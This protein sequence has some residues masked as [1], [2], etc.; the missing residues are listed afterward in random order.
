MTA[1]AIL[2]LFFRL[3]PSAFMEIPLDTAF[4]IPD[5][6]CELV[7]HR[8]ERC[9]FVGGCVRDFL[10]GRQPKDYDVEVYG[11]DYETLAAI[12]RRFG[13]VD[14]VGKSFGVIKLTTRRGQEAYDISIARRETRIAGQSGHK[15]F[16]VSHDLDLTPREGAE[17]RDFTINALMVDPKTNALLDF[18]GGR[19]DLRAGVLRHTSPKFTEDPLRPL[20]LMQ[21]A[22][23][24]DMTVA[25]ETLSLCREMLHE[26]RTLPVERIKEEWT[27]WAARSKNPARGL[28]ALA[29][30]GWIE[31]YPELAAMLRTPQDPIWH[32]EGAT[33]DGQS[34]RPDSLWIHIK[35]CCNAL[36]DLPQWQSLDAENRAVYML[37]VLCHDLGK[38]ATTHEEFKR[39][40]MCIV[41]PGHDIAGGEPTERFLRG[42]GIQQSLIERVRPL[43][44][45]H[46]AH[47]QQGGG[48]T[49][50]RR[51]ARRVAPDNIQG[52]S[53]VMIADHSGRPPL[54]RE[55]PEGT[56][57]LLEMAHELAV[58]D[59]APK[60]I[61]MGRHLLELGLRPGPEI[62]LIV[63]EAYERQLDGEFDT[64]EGALAWYKGRV[65]PG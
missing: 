3:P 7:L 13:Q 57:R 35:H 37:A 20:R 27:K 56:T 52:L 29:A 61:L 5:D 25:P 17:R 33:P 60:P 51:L 40:R 30:T 62:G 38:P 1:A 11:L 14:L 23:R 41:S 9:Y 18:F 15:A 21:F 65:I 19:E 46:M 49:M 50:V 34:S 26:Y 47:L 53:L 44:E 6:L 24:F 32:P 31:L 22:G 59:A 42:I 63:K 48:P 10:L 43:V 12:L 64:V 8:L 28:D 54:P 16:D 4:P 36:A 45:N 39:G 55:V 2:R 58:Q